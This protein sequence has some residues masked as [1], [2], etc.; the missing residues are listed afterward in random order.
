MGLGVKL[1]VRRRTLARCLGDVVRAR[2][3][4]L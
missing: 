3:G 4:V 2:R 1:Q